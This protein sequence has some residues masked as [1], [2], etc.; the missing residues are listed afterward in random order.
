M[1][2]VK[3]WNISKNFGESLQGIIDKANE[4]ALTGNI[5][6]WYNSLWVMYINTAGHKKMNKE[7]TVSFFHDLKELSNVIDS[8]ESKSVQ[9][10]VYQQVLDKN[11]KLKL[12]I[13]HR[14]LITEMHLAGLIIPIDLDERKAVYKR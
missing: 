5:H 11:L 12:L 1:E 13:L 10:K 6:L 14:E 3:D 7:K 2:E 4:G 8:N 9:S